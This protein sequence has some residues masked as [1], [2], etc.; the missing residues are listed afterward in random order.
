MQ[1]IRLCSSSPTRAKILREFGVEFI[2]SGVDFDE[3][4][5]NYNS[6]R[7]FVYYASL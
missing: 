6:P 1:I 3:D 2:Q 4:S 7:A 5:L